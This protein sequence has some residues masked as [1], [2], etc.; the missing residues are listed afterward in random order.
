MVS[1]ND[2]VFSDPSPLPLLQRFITLWESGWT[3]PNDESHTYIEYYQYAKVIVATQNNIQEDIATWLLN[4]LDDQWNF[5]NEYLGLEE[6]ELDQ[7]WSQLH[8]DIAEFLPG[9]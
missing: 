1:P 2:P 4:R 9:I 5:D 7:E 8:R 6:D 3:N